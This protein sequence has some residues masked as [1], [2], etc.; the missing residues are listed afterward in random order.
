MTL[1]EADTRAK[2][3]EPKIKASDWLGEDNVQLLGSVTDE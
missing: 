3:I 1:T 2:L